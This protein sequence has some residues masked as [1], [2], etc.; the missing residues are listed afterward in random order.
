MLIAIV[1]ISDVASGVKKRRAKP[2][3]S[4]EASDEASDVAHIG[5]AAYLLA[6]RVPRSR[7]HPSSNINTS[8]T[9]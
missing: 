9:T 8:H 4:G 7:S 2:E 3:P 5:Y 1:N 6:S